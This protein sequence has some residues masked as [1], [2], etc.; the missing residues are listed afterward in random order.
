LQVGRAGFFEVGTDLPGQPAHLELGV[1]DLH[2]ILAV[3]DAKGF[4]V[5]GGGKAGG[6]GLGTRRAKISIGTGVSLHLPCHR[7]NVPGN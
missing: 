5:T 1:Y 6:P 3:R 7:G 2:Q 4:S